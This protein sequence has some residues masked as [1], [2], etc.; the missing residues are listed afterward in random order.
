MPAGADAGLF[1]ACIT[2]IPL[3]LEFPAWVTP[4]YVGQAQGEGRLNLRDL[5]PEWEPHHPLLGGTAGT[6]AV[7]QALLRLHPGASRVGLCQ[8]RK[9]VSRQ[10][11]GTRIAKSFQTMDVVPKTELPPDRLAH[12]MSPGDQPFLVSRLF[13]MHRQGCLGQYAE[14]HRAQDLLHFTAEAVSLG[15]LAGSEA[16]AFL[17]EGEFIPGGLEM[18]VYPV[19]FWRPAMGA[20]EAV[21]RACITRHPVEPEG[22][23]ARAWAF[24][25]E[26]LGSYLL[27]RHLRGPGRR[28]EALDR[29]RHRL[30]SHWS[31]RYCGRLNLITEEGQADYV[32]GGT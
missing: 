11:V 23:Q 5:A 12:A 30:P 25:A 4:V 28:R 19:D 10:R 15:V 31:Q 24:C 27:V 2:H 3:T 29:L 16:K 7:R 32:A 18:G 13:P 6:F 22:Y 26:R 17:N 9:F 1:Y 20:V 21:V 14:V 8:Y